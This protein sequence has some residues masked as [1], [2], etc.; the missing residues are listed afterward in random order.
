MFA[1]RDTNRCYLASIMFFCYKLKVLTLPYS[2]LDLK[3]WE[4]KNW[5]KNPTTKGILFRSYLIVALS[6]EKFPQLVVSR[7]SCKNF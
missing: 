3:V 5:K 1:L 7:C 6:K 4:N 2:F